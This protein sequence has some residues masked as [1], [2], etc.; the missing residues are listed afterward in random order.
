MKPPQQNRQHLCNHSL[1]YNDGITEERVRMG[2][3]SEICVSVRIL[4]WSVDAVKLTAEHILAGW[5]DDWNV[6]SHKKDMLSSSNQSWL[7]EM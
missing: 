7:H 2:C 6:L 1:A 4:E 5:C 3:N